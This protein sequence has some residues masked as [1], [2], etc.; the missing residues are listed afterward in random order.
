MP[1]PVLAAKTLREQLRGGFYMPPRVLA[2]MPKPCG[3][4][5]YHHYHNYHITLDIGP[6]QYSQTPSLRMSLINEIIFRVFYL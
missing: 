2:S 1:P 6:V 5:Y 4:N 3:G